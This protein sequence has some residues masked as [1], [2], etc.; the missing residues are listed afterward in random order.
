MLVSVPFAGASAS[1][2]DVWGPTFRLMPWPARPASWPTPRARATRRTD[3]LADGEGAL[4]EGPG[5]GRVALSSQH[6]SYIVETRGGNGVLGHQYPLPDNQGALV[7]DLAGG[8]T[9]PGPWRDNAYVTA[10]PPAHG[11]G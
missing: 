1:L 5:G 7:Q 3:T 8:P 9:L 10:T 6:E 2:T 11:S 4:E